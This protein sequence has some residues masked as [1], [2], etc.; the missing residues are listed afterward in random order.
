M[1]HRSEQEGRWHESSKLS[2]GCKVMTAAVEAL[3]AGHRRGSCYG[4]RD[5]GAVLKKGG[6]II[7]VSDTGGACIEAEYGHTQRGDKDYTHLMI[8]SRCW[9]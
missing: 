6:G 4:T 9:I 7:G 1:P 5:I 3:S 2:A 8:H